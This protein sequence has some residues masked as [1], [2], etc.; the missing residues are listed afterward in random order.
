[1]RSPCLACDPSSPYRSEAPETPRTAGSACLIRFDPMNRCVALRRRTRRVGVGPIRSH[2]D[3]RPQWHSVPASHGMIW[4]GAASPPSCGVAGVRGRQRSAIS[5]SAWDGPSRRAAHAQTGPGVRSE[6]YICGRIR[7][8]AENRRTATARSGIIGLTIRD[9]S[10]FHWMAVGMRQVCGRLSA[11]KPFVCSAATCVP[12]RRRGCDAF[13]RF[14][15]G[16]GVA[17]L[18]GCDSLARKRP[19]KRTKARNPPE[20]SSASIA[21]SRRGS[22]GGIGRSLSRL[23]LGSS[24]WS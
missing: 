13:G 21:T 17:C 10:C 2:F 15:H 16:M 19:A 12:L 3:G 6:R 11:A 9:P 22:L 1:M 14:A 8:A 18:A 23:P 20:C 4:M 7:C 24:E 5:M